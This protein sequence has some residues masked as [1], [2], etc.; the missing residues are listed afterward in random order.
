MHQGLDRR[1]WP[2]AN[3]VNRVDQ[4]G[5]WTGTVDRSGP[6]KVD[7]IRLELT[8]NGSGTTH[9]TVNWSRPIWWT[10]D[11]SRQLSAV[12]LRPEKFWLECEMECTV[13]SRP[14]LEWSEPWTVDHS[15]LWTGVDWGLK[16]TVNL[17]VHWSWLEWS[18][19]WNRPWI[20][21]DRKPE[22]TGDWNGPMT[23]VDS[24]LD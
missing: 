21:V 1:N 13:Y 5:P 4:S 3:R 15:R 6:L 23:E 24:G 11:W 12:Y 16:W 9:L 22:C 19:V 18:M 7:W 14:I 2:G 17:T 10:G 8:A 20:R